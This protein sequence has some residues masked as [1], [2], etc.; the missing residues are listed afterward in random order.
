MNNGSKV[1][2]APDTSDQK[3]IYIG[4]D[5]K[6][7]AKM[8][9]TGWYTNLDHGRRHQYL[10][11]MSMADNFKFNKKLRGKTEY[12]KYANYEAIEVPYT[13]AIPSDYAGVM[14]VPI[15]FLD[16]YNP[17]QFE[18]VGISLFL[19]KP[20]SEIAQKGTY[21][22]GGRRFYTTNQD[23]TY[24]RLFDRIAIKHKKK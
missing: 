24:N 12:E 14:G 3:N 16:R 2:L 19:A 23:S 8:G 15:T 6:K 4:T 11:L 7:Y 9:N 10:T 18:I 21:Q 13:D 1:Y 20:M 5:G 17:D 22:Q